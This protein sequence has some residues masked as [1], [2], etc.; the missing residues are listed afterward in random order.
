M[1]PCTE[2]SWEILF[3]FP[4]SYLFLFYLIFSKQGFLVVLEIA[5]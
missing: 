2:C 1:S 4:L 5:L 3:L